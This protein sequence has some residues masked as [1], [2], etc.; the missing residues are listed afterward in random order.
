MSVYSTDGASDSSGP[1]TDGHR[2]K[3]VGSAVLGGALLVLGLRRRS[4]VG[5]AMALGG[6][7]LSYRAI[8]GRSRRRRAAEP[9][10]TAGRDRREPGMA[11]DTS[12][13]TGAVTIG[14]AADE[15]SAFVRDPENLGRIVG[16]FADVTAESE[17]RHRW[18]VRAP[19]PFDRSL[20]W[21]MRLVE[22]RPGELLRW[23]SVEGPALFDE[24]S[25]EFRPA[26]GDRGTEVTFRVRLP[27]GALAGA[28]VERFD[29]VPRTLVT[30]A[31]DR[32]KSLAETG[33]LPTLEGNPSARGRGDPL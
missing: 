32:F 31:L 33:E 14:R 1:E 11:A 12:T 8:S 2:R 3:R 24:W 30:K 25:V 21:G 13:V 29:V 10:A 28:G 6:A 15:L 17:D 16:R 5:T 4:V 9:D 27:G 26:P 23:E 20:S 19:G 22:D 7:W 18:S